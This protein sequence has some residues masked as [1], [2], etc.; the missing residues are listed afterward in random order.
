MLVRDMNRYDESS[1]QLASEMVSSTQKYCVAL[2]ISWQGIKLDF[3]SQNYVGRSFHEG[4]SY[5]FTLKKSK[6]V[7]SYIWSNWQTWLFW[8]TAGGKE[9][10]NALFFSNAM[11]VIL[12][13]IPRSYEFQLGCCPPYAQSPAIQPTA[14]LQCA[15]TWIGSEV[16][17]D[18]SVYQLE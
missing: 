12:P 5:Y 18:L 14:P 11:R 8:S 9:L 15:M 1:S 3:H 16:F 4:V 2:F 10:S 17:V 6:E 7:G 13:F